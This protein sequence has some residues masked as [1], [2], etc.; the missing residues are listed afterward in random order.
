[1]KITIESVDNGFLVE[2]HE[3]VQDTDHKSTLVYQIDEYNNFGEIDA[4]Q[5]ALYE[6]IN[7]LGLSGSRHDEKRIRV[8]LEAG[9]KYV[10]PTDSEFNG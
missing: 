5:S 8:V 2:T 4:L 6:I 1:M 10:N 7:L 9:D 3:T